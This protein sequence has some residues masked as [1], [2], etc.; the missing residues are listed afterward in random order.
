MLV[1]IFLLEKILARAGDVVQSVEHLPRLYKTL[2]LIPIY[3]TPVIPALRSWRQEDQSFKVVL[4]Y[5]VSDGQPRV[6]ETLFQKK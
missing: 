1:A 3:C 4:S 5:T 6:H 2:G